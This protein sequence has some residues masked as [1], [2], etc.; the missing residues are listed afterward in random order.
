MKKILDNTGYNLYVENENPEILADKVL[1][2]FFGRKVEISDL[3]INPFRILNLSGA[4][5]HFTEFG[6]LEGFY[7][8]PEDLESEISFAVVGINK[9]MRISRQRFTAAHE[10]CHHVKD[11]DAFY[12]IQGDS[13]SVEVYANKFASALLM[14]ITLIE[15]Y[16]KLH[17]IHEKMSDKDFL[18]ATL[19]IANTFGT[20]FESTLYSILKVVK[21]KFYRKVKSIC[22]SYQPTKKAQEFNLNNDILLHKQIFDNLEFF[23]WNPTKKV[24][25]DFLRLLITADHRMENGNLKISEIN[26]ILAKIRFDES[27]IKVIHQK[28]SDDELDVL[29]Q[30]NMYTEVF[31]SFKTESSVFTGLIKLHKALYKYAKFPEAGGTLRNSSAR[32]A[33]R[34]VTTNSPTEI[35]NNLFK[36]SEK[37]SEVVREDL[38]FTN[39]ELLEMFIKNHHEFTVIH[40]FIDGNGRTARAYLNKQL[41][42]MGLPLVYVENEKKILYQNALELCDEQENYDDLFMLFMKNLIDVY[43]NVVE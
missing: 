21:K 24:Q 28:L 32:I 10:L 14:P 4:K 37:F 34:K 3:P 29:G 30:Y 15:E 1:K 20:S 19:K 7:L 18:D 38:K 39:S 43:D 8:L 25:T 6:N 40:P 22:K 11:K 27:E 41:F 23:E 13:N 9:N 26:E 42:T 36:L 35:P 2:R 16:I 5:V 12:C 33:H 17:K 31:K